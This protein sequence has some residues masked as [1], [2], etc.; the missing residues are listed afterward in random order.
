MQKLHLYSFLRLKLVM[1]TKLD[2]TVNPVKI[3]LI[4]PNIFY[5]ITFFLSNTYEHL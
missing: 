1:L 5:Y 3:F 2:K 4:N